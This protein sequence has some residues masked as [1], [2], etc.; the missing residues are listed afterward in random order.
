MYELLLI[1]SRNFLY[2][3]LTSPVDNFLGTI[4]KTNVNIENRLI[5]F[6]YHVEI[7]YNKQFI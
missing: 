6:S 3:M 2:F 1:L 5:S 4:Y 7:N